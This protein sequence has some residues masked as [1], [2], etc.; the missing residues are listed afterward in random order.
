MP[1]NFRTI[2]LILITAVLASEA[3][4]AAP[5]D[6]QTGTSSS[7]L[8]INSLI[9]AGKS[10]PISSGKEIKLSA[11]P[12]RVEFHFGP[13]PG[14]NRLPTR[15]RYKLIGHDDDW[16][17]GLGFM[18][19]FIRFYDA[20]NEQ[21]A[22]QPSYNVYGES[23]N[24]KGSFAHSAL[25][26]RREGFTVPP[27]ASRMMVVISSAGPASTEGV[28]VIA[29]LTVSRTSPGSPMTVLRNPFDDQSTNDEAVEPPGWV[30]DGLVRNMAKIVRIGPEPTVRA[31]A[32]I[33]D[34]PQGH[35]EWHVDLDSAPRVAPGDSLVVEWNEMFSMG[36]ED[37]R[38]ATYDNLAPG[39]YLFD[40]ENV[41]LYGVPTG[42]KAE[43]SVVVLPPF[44]KTSAF[45]VCISL[46]TILAVFGVG[47]YAISQ[48]LMKQ[49]LQLQNQQAMER[50]RVRIAQDIHDDL[51]ARVT[52]ISLISAM[53]NSNGDYSEKARA[54]FG[55]ITRCSRDLVAALYETIWAVNP[56]N[57]NLY[58]L[59]D[60]ISQMVNQ[61]CEPVQV[62]C[63]FNMG[64]LPRDVLASSQVRHN[65]N[66]AVK[67]A[68]HNAIKHAKASE[69]TVS[70]MFERGVLTL[71]I[72][73]D[74]QGF[75]QPE[76][77]FGHGLTNMKKRL[78]EIGGTCRVE[79][80]IGTGTT[81]TMTLNIKG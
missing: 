37:P 68:V 2:I 35:A 6:F 47:R 14:Q 11:F 40:V 24:W 66:M 42:E 1:Q 62:R 27:R 43:L 49:T 76:K 13:A 19:L 74:G 73:D 12:E 21:I 64:D 55:Q 57:D 67:E 59:G 15:V 77:N 51:G 4:L 54:D 63:R 3:D 39:K 58:A 26:H 71:S 80:Q 61:L 75:Q 8:V 18:R 44:W 41:D 9:V 34:D 50:E 79:S 31:F 52:Q 38:V 28:Y 69:V 48:K 25:T 23:A 17:I 10:I 30:R 72:S 16:Q 56:E 36:V 53:A 78:Q 46:L 29:N 65:V 60:Y 20:E 5:Q 7:F 70:S 81:I 32:I 45:W 22:Q 33:D